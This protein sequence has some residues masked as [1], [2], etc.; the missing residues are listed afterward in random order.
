MKQLSDREKK[1]RMY[2][3]M[4]RSVENKLHG[5]DLIWWNSLTVKAR[6][7][8]VFRW[9]EYHKHYGMR[10]KHFLSAHRGRY[11]PN[12]TNKREVVLKYILD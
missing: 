2:L 7:H 10:F 9:R 8:F 4:Y 6:Y 3:N 1:R 11:V 12:L 5:K